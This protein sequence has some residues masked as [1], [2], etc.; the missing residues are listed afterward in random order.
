M[1]LPGRCTSVGLGA[2]ERAGWISSD[3]HF[4]ALIAA[5]AVYSPFLLSNGTFQLFAPEMLDKAF[6]NMLLHL[7]R[8]EV[9]V[10]RE[11]IDFEAFTHDGKTYAYFG[12]FPALL[13]LPALPFVDVAQVPLARLSCLTAVVF[14]VAVQLRMLVIVHQSLPPQ[15]QLH[16]FL[17]IMMA[18]TVLGGPQLYILGSASIYHEPI[19][20]SA[21]TTCGGD[22]RFPRKLWRPF[23]SH[24]SGTLPP[25]C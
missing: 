3:W 24:W 18:A 12:V 2:P 21:F 10:D 8:G 7:L 23:V 6:N 19:L 5:V 15:N 9:T 22:P 13:R 4:A 16:S 11:A 20:W 17:G 14:Y 25:Y 1:S